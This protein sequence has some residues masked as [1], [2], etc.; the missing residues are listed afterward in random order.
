M[1]ESPKIKQ[2]MHQG[3]TNVELQGGLCISHGANKK[4]NYPGGCTHMALDN[5]GVCA[6]HGGG[7]RFAV[8]KSCIHEG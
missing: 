2:C 7:R 8:R 4:C 3:C 1:Y 5:A 6:K